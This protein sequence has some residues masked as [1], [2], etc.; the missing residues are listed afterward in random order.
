M[1]ALYETQVPPLQLTTTHI[2]LQRMWTAVGVGTAV[3][4]VDAIVL[5]VFIFKSSP[6]NRKD[7]IVIG[8]NIIVDLLVAVRYLAN[9]LNTVMLYGNHEGCKGFVCKFCELHGDFPIFSNS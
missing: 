8:A 9:G 3:L 4:F 7:D 1:A 2:P 6:H 5:A